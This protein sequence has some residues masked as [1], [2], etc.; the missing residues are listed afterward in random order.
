MDL[1]RPLGLL[2]EDATLVVQTVQAG[3]QGE[4]S[5]V[6]RP[7]WRIVNVDG[8]PVRTLQELGAELKASKSRRLKGVRRRPRR[9]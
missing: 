6:P 2:V 1:T 7:G 8:R 4:E 5:G 3:R 9:R